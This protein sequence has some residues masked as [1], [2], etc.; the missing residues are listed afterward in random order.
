[1]NRTEPQPRDS[2]PQTVD[3]LRAEV[4]AHAVPGHVAIIM[5]G[6][7]RWAEARGLGRLAGHRQGAASVRDV[8]RACRRLGVKYLTLYAFST[9]NWGRPPGEVEGLMGLLSEFLELERD[10][11]L[12]NDV[13]L[14]AVG[15]L[16]KLPASVRLPLAAVRKLT[17]KNEG[18]TL[19]LALSY[20]GR[21][22][23]VHA[24]RELAF[25]VA[26]GD[27]EPEDID[28]EA[29]RAKL[30]TGALPDPDLVIR[31]S[32]EVRVSNFLLFHLAYA[33]IVVTPLA[34]PDFREPQLL[35]ALRDF[36]SRERRFGRTS[37]Q[38]TNGR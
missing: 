8:V 34:W 33:E 17:A 31:T 3:A 13:R 7:G 27:L 28:E 5:D 20:G 4:L 36:Q 22:E 1:M 11:L 23:L 10:E 35:R 19:T 12:S 16:E 25:A 2:A 26:R 18:L 24:A 29:L 14:N 30:W 21:E 6:N 38:T 32:G 37:A 9:Q 15:D